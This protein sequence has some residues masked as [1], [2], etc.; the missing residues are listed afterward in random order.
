MKK[1]NEYEQI[2]YSLT[3]E[4]AKN[5]GYD[6]IELIKAFENYLYNALKQNES[7][8]LK[9]IKNDKE[10]TERLLRL[11]TERL[12]NADLDTKKRRLIKDESFER[13]KKTSREAFE[14]AQSILNNKTPNFNFDIQKKI[15]ELQEAISDVKIYNKEQANELVSETI[16]DLNFIENPKTNIVSL[17]MGYLIN[18]QESKERGEK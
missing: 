4:F 9:F 10:S 15:D 8:K 13:I 1:D 7:T 12:I 11:I 2:I 18:S 16:L 3:D 5:V 17:R 6:E 14:I